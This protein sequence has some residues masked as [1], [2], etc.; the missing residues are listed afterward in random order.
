MKTAIY[1]SLLL[2]FTGCSN[3]SDVSHINQL[4]IPDTTDR[5]SRIFFNRIENAANE[6]DL[7][8]LKESTDSFEIRVWALIGVMNRHRVYVIKPKRKEWI[9]LEYEFKNSWMGMDNGVDP[10][11][12]R[13]AFLVDTFSVRK[14]QPEITWQEFTQKLE[15]Q[16]IYNLPTQIE[17]PHWKNLVSDG[18]T[19]VIE[20]LHNREYGFYFYNCPDLYAEDFEQCRKMTN[21]LGILE[22]EVGFAMWNNINFRCR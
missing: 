19:F 22:E 15:D 6:L 1:I 13:T 21:I 7:Q 8:D 18:H 9:C 20:Y 12:T 10:L 14:Y 16:N 17:I 5:L 11:I 2:V 3:H 4:S